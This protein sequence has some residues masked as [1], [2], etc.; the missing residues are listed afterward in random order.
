MNMSRGEVFNRLFQPYE[1]L[2]SA[3]P[4]T[5]RDPTIIPGSCACLDQA[6]SCRL[7]I[8]TIENRETPLHLHGL[9]L[10]INTAQS[11]SVMIMTTSFTLT[12][13]PTSTCARFTPLIISESS[14]VRRLVHA[15]IASSVSPCLCTRCWLC[16]DSG[17]TLSARSRGHELMIDRISVCADHNVFVA[18]LSGTTRVRICRYSAYDGR[19]GRTS[20]LGWNQQTFLEKSPGPE[21]AFFSCHARE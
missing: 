12:A 13:H 21:P 18:C 3:P 7:R 1:A 16:L 15:D 17:A 9:I 11:P 5:C 4:R 6:R 14:T 2:L 20:Y 19:A 8:D 10:H